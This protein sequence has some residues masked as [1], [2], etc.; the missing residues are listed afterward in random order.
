VESKRNVSVIRDADGNN[1]VMINDIAFKGKRS[2]NW[3]DVKEY[4]KEFVGNNYTIAGSNEVVYI[5]TD[6]PDEYTG[7]DYTYSLKGAVAKAKANAA[8]GLGELIEIATNGKHTEN[9]KKKHNIDGANGWYRYDSCFALPVY[10][11]DNKVERYNVFNV[12]LIIRHDLDGRKY[13]YDIINIKK[14]TSNPLGC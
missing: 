7:S 14:E 1:I 5:G 4:L 3:D 8:Q 10:G 9:K 2:M 6:L 13:L 11:V 12:N